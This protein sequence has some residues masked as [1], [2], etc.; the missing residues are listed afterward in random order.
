MSCGACACQ[1]YRLLAPACHEYLRR[2][3]VC[4]THRRHQPFSPRP[5]PT[6]LCGDSRQQ[7]AQKSIFTPRVMLRPI[8]GAASLMKL[9]CA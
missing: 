2:T 4:R 6:S 7:G 3:T 5:P 9:V 1:R 8:S